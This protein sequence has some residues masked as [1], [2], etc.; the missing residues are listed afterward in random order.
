MKKIFVLLSYALVLFS[1]Y[2]L[3]N[4]EML[5][6]QIKVMDFSGTVT[7]QS[8]DIQ[9]NLD[10]KKG[11]LLK[12]NSII[13][14]GAV[15]SAILMFSNGSMVTLDENS[16]LSVADYKL[17]KGKHEREAFAPRTEEPSESSTKLKLNYGK[18]FTDVAKLSPKSSM[19][20][21]T[22]L[23]VAG[24]RGTRLLS[25]VALDPKTGKANVEVDLIDGKVEL[26]CYE[27]TAGESKLTSANLNAGSKAVMN[28]QIDRSNGNIKASNVRFDSLTCDDLSSIASSVPKNDLT[29]DTLA[30]IQ[31]TTPSL[32]PATNI[33]QE[34]DND[35]SLMESFKNKTQAQE[36]FNVAPIN[37]GSESIFTNN[38]MN[39][40][41]KPVNTEN[42]GKM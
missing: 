19:E 7:I 29:K 34:N 1:S 5:R 6:G 3:L 15:S 21:V 38:F 2:S 13:T 41:V 22:P 10:A 26:T 32:N 37:S 9:G 35:G 11:M 24:I 28:A 33:R 30:A 17:N 4:A 18:M 20:I 8:K 14:T 31:S 25:Q 40:D 42:S 27:K 12:D 16:N 23:G 39:S 36:S